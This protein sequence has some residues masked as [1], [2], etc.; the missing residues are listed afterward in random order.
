MAVVSDD[1]RLHLKVTGDWRCVLILQKCC[2]K[3]VE[4]LQSSE[5][6]AEHPSELVAG[7]GCDTETV[8]S[9]RHF[10]GK[11][12]QERW[13]VPLVFLKAKL[14]TNENIHT[15][16]CPHDQTEGHW[17]TEG[18]AVTDDP[19]HSQLYLC[20]CPSRLRGMC[21]CQ[22]LQ[23]FLGLFW[24][25]CGLKCLK[26]MKVVGPLRPCFKGANYL[27]KFHYFNPFM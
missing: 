15:H 16:P 17:S 9:S 4:L 27:T 12:Q 18:L 10:R 22:A 24:D 13:K 21:A 3:S 5:G 11:W 14:H 8:H 1:L 19:D 7:C 25:C 6:S 2:R 20:W 23:D 26:M